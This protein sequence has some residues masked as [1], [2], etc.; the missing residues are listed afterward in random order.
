M[1]YGDEDLRRLAEDA[2]FRT[3][4]WRRD[5]V[6]AY[7]KKI[8]LLADAKDERDLR[9]MRSLNLEKPDGDRV[10]NCSIRLN[11]QFRLALTFHD[12]D[13]VRVVVVLDLVDYA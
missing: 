4:R 6:V 10:G 7:R 5:V 13:D 8:Q 12:E 9:A 3:R 1:E 2:G 11:D